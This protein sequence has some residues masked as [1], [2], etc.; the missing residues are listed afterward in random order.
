MAVRWF[1]GTL[2]EALAQAA[3]EGKLV[4]VEVGAYWCEPCHLLEEQTFVDPRVGEALARGYIALRVDVEKEDGADIGARYKVPGY[5]TMLVLEPSGM[6][7]GR[8]VDFVPPDELLQRLQAIAAG[9]NVLAKLEAAAEARPDDL[10][11]A[12]ELMHGRAMAGERDA[13][14]AAAEAIIAADPRNELGL[15]AKAWFDRT[16]LVTEKLD[17]DYERAVREYRELQERFAGSPQAVK[18]YR[19]TAVALHRLGRDDEALASAEA[20]LAEDPGDADLYASFVWFCFREKLGTERGI[21]VAD[22]GLA[23]APDK[24]E[25]H[26]LKAELHSRAGRGSDAVAAIE[27]AAAAEP[28]S[29]FYRRQVRRFQR[30]ARGEPAEP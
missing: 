3:T 7:K 16:Q 30:L 5:P 19:R 21:V 8:I 24:A 2:D 12:Y 1:A 14:V 15:A 29:A 25:L 6:E 9:E 17:K 20:M 10:Q 18:A 4:F 22:K 11:A 28:K 27:A 26:Y 23:L 13:A